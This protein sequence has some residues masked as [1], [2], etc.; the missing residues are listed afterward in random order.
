[1]DAR[2][3]VAVLFEAFGVPATVTPPSAA[4]VTT[5]VVWITPNPVLQPGGDLNRRD[6]QRIVAIRRDE[7]PSVPLGTRID[8]P[9]MAGG[10]DIEWRVDGTDLV[11]QDHVRVF[12]LRV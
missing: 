11:E 6:G 4:A 10:A 8:A 7:V 5:T 9:E 3:P 12:V 2:P 1:M